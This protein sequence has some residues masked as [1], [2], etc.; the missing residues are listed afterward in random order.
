MTPYHLSV[1]QSSHWQSLRMAYGIMMGWRHCNE[2]MSLKKVLKVLTLQQRISSHYQVR[3]DYNAMSLHSQQI[4]K[5]Q[6][7]VSLTQTH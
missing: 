4:Q 1:P 3:L 2:T 7:F 5:H 6:I